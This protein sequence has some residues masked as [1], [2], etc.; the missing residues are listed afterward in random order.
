[1]QI[2]PTDNKVRTKK[3]MQFNFTVSEKYSKFNITF[4]YFRGQPNSEKKI[5][6]P[7]LTGDQKRKKK[8]GSRWHQFNQDNIRK[9]K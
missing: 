3:K 4:N 9:D 1:M 5:Q 2:K 8:L 6:T 7:T